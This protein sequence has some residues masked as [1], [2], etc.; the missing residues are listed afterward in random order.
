M[1]HIAC[2]VD[3]TITSAPQQFEMLLTALRAADHRVTIL[4]GCSNSPVTK[5]DFDAKVQLLSGLGCVGCW[6]YMVVFG[7]H[8]DELAK[9]KAAWMKEHH[10]D[11]FFDNDERNVAAATPVVPLVLLPWTTRKH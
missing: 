4:T 7:C 3:G 8:G 5:A 9:A 11:L 6:D 2:D 1:A 10:V